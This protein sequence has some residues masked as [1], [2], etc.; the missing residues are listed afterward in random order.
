MN[1]KTEREPV[2]GGQHRGD[3]LVALCPSDEWCGCRPGLNLSSLQELS[4]CFQGLFLGILNHGVLFPKLEGHGQISALLVRKVV[5][6]S[7]TEQAELTSYRAIGRSVIENFLFQN[8]TCFWD[9]KQKRIL[10]TAVQHV[11][12][13]EGYLILSSRKSL[14]LIYLLKFCYFSKLLCC[15]PQFPFPLFQVTTLPSHTE[16]GP[17]RRE[18]EEW[19]GRRGREARVGK[20]N[21]WNKMFWTAGWSNCQEMSTG[22][23]ISCLQYIP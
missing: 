12:C 9:Q 17:G 10:D 4:R 7:N 2:Q 22:L 16:I 15:P 1:S 14:L 5:I 21:Q 6:Q 23:F 11:L 19:G 20:L 18:A 3:V 8:A 13:P